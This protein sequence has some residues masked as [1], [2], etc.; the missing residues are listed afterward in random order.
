MYLALSKFFLKEH[1]N[2]IIIGFAIKIGW[3]L[4]LE[5]PNNF[6]I[7]FS[8]GKASWKFGKFNKSSGKAPK[9]FLKKF[10]LK[11]FF[12][13][14]VQGCIFVKKLSILIKKSPGKTEKIP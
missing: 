4:V 8:P 2:V 10:F 11:K 3:P 1:F 14:S 12:L 13:A 5:S 9:F 6:G 7:G